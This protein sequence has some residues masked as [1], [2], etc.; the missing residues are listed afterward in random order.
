MHLAPSMGGESGYEVR[1][2][3]FNIKMLGNLYHLSHEENPGWL[4][5]I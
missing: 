2:H 3:C 1:F 5:Y 4:G